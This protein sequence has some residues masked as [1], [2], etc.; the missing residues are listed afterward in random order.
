M[1]KLHGFLAAAAATLALTSTAAHADTVWTFVYSGGA[2]GVYATGSFATAGDGTTPTTVEWISGTYTDQFVEN[3]SISLIP[4]TTTPWGDAGQTLSA[5]GQYYYD[6]LFNKTTGFDDGGLLFNA[7]TQ[8]V[9]L[10]GGNG[11]FINLDSGT[12]TNVSFM[13]VPVPEPAPTAMLLAGLGALA[14]ASR[15]KRV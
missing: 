8:E 13:A 1:N 2:N 9:N 3:G 7:G 15:R 4:T 5:D 6:N 10:Y 11:G 14:F 12:T